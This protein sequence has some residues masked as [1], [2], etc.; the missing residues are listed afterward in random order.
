MFAISAG[1]VLSVKRVA[2]VCPRMRFI[3]G[4]LDS[5]IFFE[6][7]LM[8]APLPIDVATMNG[9]AEPSRP[10]DE[11]AVC[12]S[13]RPSDRTL[14]GLLRGLELASVIILALLMLPW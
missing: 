2:F 7:R 13:V 14:P 1:S 5:S 6:A 11:H 4:L 8:L 9:A 3:V 10:A 12:A